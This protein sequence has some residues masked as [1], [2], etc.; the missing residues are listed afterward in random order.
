MIS[1][2]E[3]LLA[4]SFE[5]EICSMFRAVFVPGLRDNAVEFVLALSVADI[6]IA[7]G[8]GMKL[9]LT[10]ASIKSLDC[11]KHQLSFT[12]VFPTSN[13]T[14]FFHDVCNET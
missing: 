10:P 2:R 4:R 1:F 3:I 7:D 13:Q 11:R 6:T 9:F 12:F 14:L 8:G 5:V